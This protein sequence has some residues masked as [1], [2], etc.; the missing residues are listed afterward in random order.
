MTAGAGPK[1]VW[2][3]RETPNSRRRVVSAGRGT[4]DA[5]DFTMTGCGGWTAELAPTGGATCVAAGRSSELP[6]GRGTGPTPGVADAEG[7]DVPRP[8][9]VSPLPWSTE[10]RFATAPATEF[11]FR[12]GSRVTAMISATPSATSAQDRAMTRRGGCSAPALAITRSA[13]T[14]PGRGDAT[15]TRADTEASSTTWMRGE[16]AAMRTVRSLRDVHSGA[17][18]TSRRT[19]VAAAWG[20]ATAALVGL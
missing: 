2:P 7:A 6:G 9:R 18:R 1:I 19:L 4:G 13:T 11:P 20:A 10:P 15:T 12:F 8:T 17:A 16:R 14:L 5:T 3:A